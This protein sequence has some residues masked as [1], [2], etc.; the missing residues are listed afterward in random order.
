MK[1]ARKKIELGE[2]K[3]ERHSGQRDVYKY[4]ERKRWNS[5]RRGGDRVAEERA[6][7]KL[8]NGTRSAGAPDGA[9]MDGTNRAEGGMLKHALRREQGVCRPAAAPSSEACKS[10]ILGCSAGGWAR[11]GGRTSGKRADPIIARAARGQDRIEW[12]CTEKE[13]RMY[14]DALSCSFPVLGYIRTAQTAGER[15][16]SNELIVTARGE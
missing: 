9:R 14:S 6:K 3:Q 10:S 13:E 7:V 11:K 12:I 16:R 4:K 2:L 1:R 5:R 8:G 15:E